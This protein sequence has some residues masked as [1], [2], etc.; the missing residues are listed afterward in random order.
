MFIIST[1]NFFY[2]EQK[3]F[4]DK[5]LEYSMLSKLKLRT[6]MNIINT[7]GYSH[8]EFCTTFYKLFHLE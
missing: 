1:F 6:L 2:I 8:E 3:L 4:A 7:D 5:P